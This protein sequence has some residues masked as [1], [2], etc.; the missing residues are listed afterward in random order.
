MRANI[1]NSKNQRG[2]SKDGRTTRS[3]KGL[4]R[5][6]YDQKTQTNRV[7]GKGKYCSIPC[8]TNDQYDKDTKKTNIGLFK[9]PD[10]TRKPDLYKVW[11][12]KIKNLHN[13]GGKDVFTV[14]NNNYV[15]EFQFCNI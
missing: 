6:Y 13:K 12:N 8:C 1:V 10:Y 9:F 3:I 14:T 11:Y 5:K 15:C 2:R 4:L 7:G